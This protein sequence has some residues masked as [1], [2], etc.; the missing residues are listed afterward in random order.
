M[1]TLAKEN[2]VFDKKSSLG[3][4]PVAEGAEADAA[5]LKLRDFQR[6]YLKIWYWEI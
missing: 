1:P 3:K 6:K 5:W 4:L 2:V